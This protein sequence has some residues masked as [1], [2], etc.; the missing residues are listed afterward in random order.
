MCRTAR[1]PATSS[2]TRHGLARQAAFCILTV[3]RF[4][5]NIDALFYDAKKNFRIALKPCSSRVCGHLFFLNRLI[6]IFWPTQ[7]DDY[8][9][10]LVNKPSRIMNR[11]VSIIF[12][13]IVGF[14]RSVMMLK[15]R[16]VLHL[17]GDEHIL[18]FF[19]ISSLP[20]SPYTCQLLMN[21]FTGYIFFP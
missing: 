13:V 6:S 11:Q 4:R 5:R 21:P 3:S 15:Y 16:P 7:T 9:P 19:L 2:P 12:A 10:A 1:F 8:P 17:C 18:P 20:F 14:L